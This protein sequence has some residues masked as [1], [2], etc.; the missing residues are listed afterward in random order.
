MPIETIDA[1]SSS[2]DS[3]SILHLSDLHWTSKTNPQEGCF[4]HLEARLRELY[5]NAKRCDLILV[6]GDLVDNSEFALGLH[7]I[8]LKRVRKYLENLAT[9]WSVNGTNALSIIPGN[10]DYRWSGIFSS[11]SSKSA[12]REVLGAYCDHRVIDFQGLKLKLLLACFDSIHTK[13]DNARGYVDP[14]QITEFAKEATEMGL[15]GELIRIALVHHHP[16]PVARADSQ[17]LSNN[18]DRVFGKKVVGA[19]EYMLLRNSGLFLHKLMEQ[20]FRLVLHGHLHE[21]GYWR[22]LTRNYQN[23]EKWIEVVSGASAGRTDTS[24]RH[25]FN[26]IN[27]YRDGFIEGA[28]HAWSSEGHFDPQISI[29]FT[30]YEVT[31]T[32]GTQPCQTVDLPAA[33]AGRTLEE[34]RSDKY[35]QLWEVNPE[36]GDYTSTE[37]HRGFR[38]SEKPLDSIL[39]STLSSATTLTRYEVKKLTGRSTLTKERPKYT[40]AHDG[41]IDYVIKFDPRLEIT[42]PHDFVTKYTYRGVMFRSKEDQAKMGS[43]SEPGWDSIEQRVARQTDHMFIKLRFLNSGHG[44]WF[45][46]EIQFEVI[47]PADRVCVRERDGAHIY[48][49][50][51]SQDQLRLSDQKEAE[52]ILSIHKPRLGYK[53]ILKWR[54][55][56]SDGESDDTVLHRRRLIEGLSGREGRA[57]ANQIV[58]ELFKASAEFMATAFKETLNNADGGYLFAFEEDADKNK[59]TG[60]LV[61]LESTGDKQDKLANKRIAY[62]KDVIGTS[63]RRREPVYFSSEDKGLELFRNVPETFH[64]IIAIPLKYPRD[65]GFPVAVFALASGNNLSGLRKLIDNKE[66]I[67]ELTKNLSACWVLACKSIVD[68]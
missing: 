5:G 23:V 47:D 48:F 18:L 1:K 68:P 45:P 17:E 3:A 28:Q 56:E 54:L 58:A 67:A 9:K 57:K 62:G 14:K 66:G 40:G 4:S 33:F 27:I 39:I 22:A 2:T 65:K 50:Y 8:T 64:Y 15:N 61:C 36:Q 52:A 21:R 25:N 60:E 46:D 37:I 31:R 63:F 51:P 11:K 29:P 44:F 6:T 41:E 16:L 10:H 42:T 30:P 32:M 59:K 20:K 24:N 12:F 34:G 26:I 19:D 49:D 53:Y 38:A 35:I 13:N 43:K 7:E 55:P